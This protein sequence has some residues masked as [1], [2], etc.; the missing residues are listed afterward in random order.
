ANQV[1]DRGCERCICQDN[2]IV[3]ATQPDC[4]P[5]PTGLPQVS[6]PTT[7]IPVIVTEEVHGED[8]CVPGWS[9]WFNTRKPDEHGDV[10]SVDAIRERGLP[11]CDERF[12]TEVQCEPRDRNVVFE[13]THRIRCDIQNGLAC[14]NDPQYNDTECPDYMV[15][16]Y[17]DCFKGWENTPVTV[18]QPTVPTTPAVP[19]TPT[20]P[21]VTPTASDTQTTPTVRTVRTTLPISTIPT[22]P[23]MVPGEDFTTP[24]D[25]I[26]DQTTVQYSKDK[27]SSFVYLVNGPFPLPDSSYKASSSASAS[28]SPRHS[29]L[30]STTTSTSLGAWIPRRQGIRRIHRGGP[31]STAKCVWHR[32]ARARAHS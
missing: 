16:F 22:A 10:E 31:R 26:Y 27:C 7:G 5:L 3:C 32:L 23:P 30:G 13:E 11:L 1:V 29:R 28:S 8:T 15:R 12:R 17:C 2:H 18:R 9:M 21:A 19:N 20:T 6:I 14:R 25:I 24:T 4:R